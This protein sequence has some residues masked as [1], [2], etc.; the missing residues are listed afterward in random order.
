ML[1]ASSDP[2]EFGAVTAWQ[3]DGRNAINF[4]LATKFMLR[5]DDIIFVA[6]Q[7]VTRWGRIIQQITPALIN[8]G[9]NAASN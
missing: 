1:R 9:V 2:R 5:P 8:T 4:L 7:P 6:E 3:M